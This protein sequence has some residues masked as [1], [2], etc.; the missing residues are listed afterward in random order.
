MNTRSKNV[1]LLT[2]AGAGVLA[3]ALVGVGLHL[4]SSESTSSASVG[5]AAALSTGAVTVTCPDVAGAVGDVPIAS[6]AGVTAEL[7][8]L[9]KQIVNV[10]NRLARE[11]GQATNQ[12]NDLAGKRGAVI[13]RIVL[14]ITRVGGAAP[15]GLAALAQCSLSGADAGAG[16]G[17]GTATTAPAA[18]AGAGAGA[19]AATGV[20]TVNCPTV[21]DKLPA[22]PA[23]AAAEVERNLTLLDTQIAEANTRLAGLAVKPEGGANFVQNAIVGPLKDK[24]FAVLNRIA[25]AIERIT[26]V[27]DTSLQDLAACSV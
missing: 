4:S 2:A 5:L 3:I 9:E 14:D 26:K 10:N 19:G 15:T 17:A 22:I 23:G 12:L 25:T 16:A 21:E 11:P 1:G 6:Q 13:D 27:R 7:A 18:D 20:Q 24:R 8:N